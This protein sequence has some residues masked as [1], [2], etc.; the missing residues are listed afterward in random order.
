M[1]DVYGLLEKADLVAVA[2]P[3]FFTDRFRLSEGISRSVP[4]VL[5]LKI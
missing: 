5:V 4:E 2:S 1:Q 3:I